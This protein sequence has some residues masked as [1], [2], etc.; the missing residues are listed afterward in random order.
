MID[1]KNEFIAVYQ[2]FLFCFFF[3]GMAII[4]FHQKS[5]RNSFLH[6]GNNLYSSWL[7]P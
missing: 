2:I 5:Q 7:I 3:V 1:K 4:L 6:V